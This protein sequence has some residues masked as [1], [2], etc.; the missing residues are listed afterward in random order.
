MILRVIHS[1]SKMHVFEGHAILWEKIDTLTP[2]RDEWC[3]VCQ[4]VIH[5]VTVHEGVASV[6]YVRACVRV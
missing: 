6:P 3:V 1:C 2:K 5:G 4:T